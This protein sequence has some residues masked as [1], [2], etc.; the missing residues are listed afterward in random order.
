MAFWPPIVLAMQGVYGTKI[1]TLLKGH[2]TVDWQ[3]QCDIPF[4][5]SLVVENKCAL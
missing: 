3:R 5:G 4:V 2:A 1:C